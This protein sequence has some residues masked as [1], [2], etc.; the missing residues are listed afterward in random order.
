M[1]KPKLAEGSPCSKGGKEIKEEQC[2]CKTRTRM[3]SGSSAQ[4]RE[5][6]LMK[7]LQKRDNWICGVK[8][9]VMKREGL[10]RSTFSGECKTWPTPDLSKSETGIAS[11]DCSSNTLLCSK[12]TI[13]CLKNEGMVQ[14]YHVE[15]TR[16]YLALMSISLPWTFQPKSRISVRPSWLV[17]TTRR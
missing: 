11:N 17:A 10:K 16:T 15:F 3:R 7:M 14:Q 2:K 5:K 8:A 6:V 9:R 1:E 4:C 12:V 13:S